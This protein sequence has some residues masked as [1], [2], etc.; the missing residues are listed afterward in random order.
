MTAT[1]IS[2][3]AVTFAFGGLL[4]WVFWPSRRQRLEAHGEIPFADEEGHAGPAE[5]FDR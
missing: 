5:G 1:I 3:L 4:V 2:L